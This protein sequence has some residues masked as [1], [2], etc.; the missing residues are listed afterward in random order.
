MTLVLFHGSG[1]SGPNFEAWVRSLV[2]DA[3]A[4]VEQRGSA[5]DGHSYTFLT[6]VE[7]VWLQTYNYS[8]VLNSYLRARRFCSFAH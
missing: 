3:V 5:G 4:D 6:G 7:L 8:S 2:P 1:D